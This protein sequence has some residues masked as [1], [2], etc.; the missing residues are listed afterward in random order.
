M[1]SSLYQLSMATDNSENACPQ[2][3]AVLASPAGFVVWCDQCDWNV[4]PTAL[5]AESAGSLQSIY[6]R[7]GRNVSGTLFE[8]DS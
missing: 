1:A 2:C 5:K 4:D 7:L 8:S 3:G 6:R